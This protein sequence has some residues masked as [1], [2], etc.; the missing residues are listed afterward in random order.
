MS[1]DVIVSVIVV[2]VLTTLFSSST[3]DVSVEV[4][5]S[6]TFDSVVLS[7]EPLP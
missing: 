4:L 5:T 3:L 7:V 6:T 2:G 1:F